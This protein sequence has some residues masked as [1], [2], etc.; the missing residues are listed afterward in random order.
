[1]EYK[2][3]AKGTSNEEVIKELTKDLEKSCVREECVNKDREQPYD[4]NNDDDKTK[5]DDDCSS[6]ACEVDEIQN[7]LEE[8]EYFV[9]EVTLKDRDLELREEQRQELKIQSEH[10]KSKGNS[11]FREGEYVN[12]TST[13]TEGLR[14]CPLIYEKDRAILF[15][16]RAAAKAK[17]MPDKI[18]AISDCTKA[19]ELDPVY[20][21]AYLRRAHFYEEA[22]KL[23]E[24]LADYK[25]VLT[26]DPAHTESI[27][28]IK[29]LEP[30]IQ[31]RNEKLKEEMLS[32]LKDLGNM[33]LRP[34]GLS[35]NN[36]QMQKDES[37]GGYSVK[38]NQN[39]T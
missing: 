27:C 8:D 25:K 23:D 24:A 35:T 13:Y 17:F 4:I 31:E 5:E 28:A 14:T 7:D 18:S 16:N 20:V 32:K 30:M 39:P 36:F 38:F 22:D 9:D 33:I 12:A 19:I 11:L 21:K 1:M 29:K 2:S 15:A 37:S 10:L 26:F 3:P 6:K 34:F